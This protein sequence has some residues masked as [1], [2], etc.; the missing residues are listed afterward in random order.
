MRQVFNFR[1]VTIVSAV[2]LDALFCAYSAEV[3]VDNR[4]GALEIEGEIELTGAGGVILPSLSIPAGAR[5]VY[6]PVATPI[7]VSAPPV[8]DDG[9]SLAL[10]SD[11]AGVALGR[12]VLMTYPGFATIP[13]GLF[14]SSSV[15]AVASLSQ[16]T[17]PDGS[18][19]QLILT[20]G[21]YA[22]DSKEIRILPIGDSI[23]HGYVKN[24]NGYS[25]QAQYRTA[26]AARLAANG[27]RPVMLGHLK[28]DASGSAMTVDA[29]SVRQPEEWI[30]HSGV[31]GDRII[32]S[33]TSGTSGGV[34]DNLHVYLDVAGK[35]D[36]ITLLIGTNDLGS[37]VS[38]E[39]TFIAY[40]NLVWEIA[41][42]S[43]RTK[44]VASTILERTNN[45]T[46]ARD[47][48]VPFNN[49]L[50]SNLTH[51]PATF[52][53]TNLCAAVPQSI[54]GA[55]FDGLHPTM[56]GCA[57]ISKGFAAT[58][59]AELPLASYSGPIDDTLTDEPQVALGAAATVPAEYRAG[60][61]HV[62]TLDAADA[63]NNFYG[64]SPYTAVN[65]ALTPGT[66]LKRAGYYMELVRAGT[67]RRRYVWVDF[68]AAGRPLDEI[69]FPWTGK[70]FHAVVENL[71]VYSNDSSIHN[72]DAGVAGYCGVVEATST[73]YSG[74]DN[75]ISGVPVDLM[76]GGKFGWND[77]LGES[78][79]GHGCFQVHRIFSQTDDDAHWNDAE[80]LFAWNRWGGEPGV[81]EIG[82][83]TFANH[84][85]NNTMDYTY[86][87]S[88][89]NGVEE[90]V[91]AKAYQVR[92]LEIW[93]E[94]FDLDE[95][96]G[97]WLTESAQ[98]LGWTGEWSEEIEYRKDARAYLGGEIEYTPY[99]A[100]TGNVVAV[101]I[102]MQFNINAEDYI[103]DA[104]A[105]AAVQISTN[106]CF[107]VWT[108][109]ELG[110][111][112]GGVGELGWV[113][114][115]A[116]G[117]TPISG[118]EYTLRFSFNYSTGTYSVDLKQNDVWLPLSTST[119]NS[120]THPLP[121]SSTSN[122]L[123]AT[124][125]NCVSSISFVGDTLFTSLSGECRMVVIGFAENETVVLKDNAIAI[126]DAAKAAWLNKCAGGNKAAAGSAAANVSS[127]EFEE[128]YLL[129]LDIADGERSYSFAIAEVKVGDENVTVS[130]T[131]KRTGIAGGEAA[132]INGTLKFYGAS[133]L[134]TF[135]NASSAAIET[136]NLTDG[137][138]SKSDMATAKFPKGENK[139]FKA[140]IEE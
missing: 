92:H 35:P 79:A 116:Q 94:P 21:D 52:F 122:F 134:E 140:K 139:F 57:P 29:A 25:Q 3:M 19:T 23:T 108:R 124:A 42:Q 80:V 97:E 114:V 132:P 24:I 11:Y 34:R 64:T 90:T 138:F 84:A 46:G 131:L 93:A 67:N 99:S 16:E 133:T 66:P 101:D 15:G 53:C 117:V 120:S 72:I 43:P 75:Q 51:L 28:I 59:M 83:G 125:T 31:S 136:T 118:A 2:F 77:T 130:V 54:S 129:N 48:V 91:S 98:V 33:T 22:N 87:A 110:I 49:L 10:S 44:I 71:H 115:E 32:S 73:N 96:K 69:D 41:R 50:L 104:D 58:I 1:T 86:T 60:M 135:K 9:A 61:T 102:K 105:Q 89:V 95:S 112:S 20:V 45:A 13:E 78:G 100:S 109:K 62:F 30:W 81:D 68:N 107:Q 119:L 74:A 137:D 39:E 27:Y 12:I 128:A 26:I 88:A 8:F 14:D 113:D 36:V 17:A 103:P 106:G 7:K 47:K 111:E 40:T 126:L 65:A 37:G 82:I 85:N 70:K 63:A 127:K 4:L 18:N 76:S 38:A 56:K 55:Y 121:Q 123:L 6:D 5:L